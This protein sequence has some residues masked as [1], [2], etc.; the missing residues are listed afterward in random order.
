MLRR[1]GVEVAGRI[2][3]PEGDGRGGRGLEAAEATIALSGAGACIAEARHRATAFLT[4]Y[5]RG[6]RSRV[7]DRVVGLAELVV[8]ELVTN[9]CKYAPGPVLLCLRLAGEALEVEVW[10]S[11]PVLPA[12]SGADPQRVGRHGLEIV[13]AVV[14]DLAVLRE[15][16][17][18]RITARILLTAT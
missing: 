9:A 17:G 15:T 10:D 18:K 13:E 8:S 6:H 16:V 5:E 2:N 11:D 14:A 4:E 3:E 12:V 1:D 7:P